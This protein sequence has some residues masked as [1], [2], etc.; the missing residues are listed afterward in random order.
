MTTENMANF[1]AKNNVVKI[2]VGERL[3]A[4]GKQLN[5]IYDLRRSDRVRYRFTDGERITLLHIDSESAPDFKPVWDL[6]E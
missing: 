1:I 2:I 5:D 6:G 4:E 3:T